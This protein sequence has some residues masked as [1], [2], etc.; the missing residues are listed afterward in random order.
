[1]PSEGTELEAVAPAASAST[2][3]WL[4]TLYL[5]TCEDLS[6]LRLHQR[7]EELLLG[8][9]YD[10]AIRYGIRSLPLVGK[11]KDT[12]EERWSLDWGRAMELTALRQETSLLQLRTLSICDSDP[13]INLVPC[14]FL[15]VLT[16]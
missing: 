3:G 16:F 7:R 4:P 6:L 13:L 1:M 8:L 12:K 9:N 11:D 15:L 14:F 5:G 10:D 2:D